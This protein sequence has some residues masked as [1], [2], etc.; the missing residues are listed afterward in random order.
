Q[1]LAGEGHRL[2]REPRRR[3]GLLDHD[4]GS[5]PVD[6]ERGQRVAELPGDAVPARGL[7]TATLRA[8]R[9]SVGDATRPSSNRDTPGT[10]A[11]APVAPPY[12]RPCVRPAA[13]TLGWSFP[14]PRGVPT[15]PNAPASASPDWRSWAATWPAISP[16][17][18]TSSPCTTGP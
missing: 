15:C 16:G 1:H 13:T 5:R 8:A 11:A 9:L 17:T 6:G 2:G 12:V 3:G 4:L 7:H 10:P 14:K 18:V